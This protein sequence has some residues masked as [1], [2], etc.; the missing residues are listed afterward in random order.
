MPPRLAFMLLS[1]RRMPH[2]IAS[3]LAALLLS[4]CGDTTISADDYR[5]SCSADAECTYISVGDVCSCA[6]EAAGIHIDDQ[7][8]AAADRAAI[9]C[10]TQCGAC[11][12]VEAFCDQGQCEVRPAP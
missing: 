5:R 6:C 4:A 12:A 1:F 2:P 9:E 3:L 11:Q 10:D 8:R 7:A